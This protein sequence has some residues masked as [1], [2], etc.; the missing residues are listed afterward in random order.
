MKENLKGS[1]ML[2]L[3]STVGRMSTLAQQEMYFGQTF[4]MDE[5]LLGIDEVDAEQIQQM[6]RRVFADEGIAVDVLAQR[7]V[8][9]KLNARFGDGLTLPAGSRLVLA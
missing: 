7:S 2:G 8:A 3:E 5:I 1:V 9:D 6:A 4:D